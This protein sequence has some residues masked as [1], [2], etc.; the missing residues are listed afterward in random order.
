MRTVPQGVHAV[1]SFDSQP[2][3]LASP[4]WEQRVVPLHITHDQPLY[5]AMERDGFPVAY[6]PPT[7]AGDARLLRELLAEPDRPDSDDRALFWCEPEPGSH[8]HDTARAAMQAFGELQFAGTGRWYTVHPFIMPGVE[9]YERE[10]APEAADYLADWVA[11][12][13]ESRLVETE[14]AER[15]AREKRERI[16]REEREAQIAFATNW[17]ERAGPLAVALDDEASDECYA[18]NL[19]AVQI[20]PTAAGV[21][22]LVDALLSDYCRRT[23][24]ERR[25]GFLAPKPTATDAA[26]DSDYD[27]D[28]YEQQRR[29]RGAAFD[30]VAEFNYQMAVRRASDP[31]LQEYQADVA[32]LTGR[33]DGGGDG[34]P[35]PPTPPQPEGTLGEEGAA[36]ASPGATGR[37]VISVT[38]NNESQVRAAVIDELATSAEWLFQGEDG[39]VELVRHPRTGALRI[40]PLDTAGIRTIITEHVDVTS[41]NSKGDEASVHPPPWL[42]RAVEVGRPWRGVRFLVG[43]A[44]AP[45][46]RADG[47]LCQDIGYDPA[48]GLYYEP[49]ADYAPIPENPTLED[50]KAAVAL[51]LSGVA[52]FPFIDAIDRAAWLAYVLTLAGRPAIPGACPFFFATAN[53]PGSGKTALMNAAVT[54]VTGEPADTASY[55]N[56]G[57]D[58]TPVE[59]EAEIRKL[60]RA[61]AL[62]GRPAFILDNVPNGH[63]FGSGTL[64]G[65]LTMLVNSDRTLGGNDASPLP[66][67]TVW[68]ATGNNVGPRGDSVRRCVGI[69]LCSEA[70]HPEEVQYRGPEVGQWAR[71]ERHRLLPA[72]LTILVAYIRAGKP[73]QRLPKMGSFDEWSDLVRSALVWC[74]QPDCRATRDVFAADDPEARQTAALI[75]LLAAAG[76]EERPVT[77]GHV[78]GLVLTEMEEMAVRKAGAAAPAGPPTPPRP[79]TFADLDAIEVSA[80]SVAAAYRRAVPGA[81]RIDATALGKLLAK[82]ASRTAGGRRIE[83]DGENRAKVAQWRVRSVASS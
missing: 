42:P 59:D 43:V 48:S 27:P 82:Y 22:L 38:G 62:A 40:A 57:S 60:G 36:P 52:Q 33:D 49:T 70:E 28:L 21:R 50:A 72:A 41:K 69:R 47:S 71:A 32:T 25:I 14:K 8:G 9:H 15:R 77:A 45:I 23:D 55:P 76:A 26:F 83:K 20:T 66:A 78:V 12:I 63:A 53:S 64:D 58:R 2:E 4:N 19:D 10:M 39:L 74:G 51:L 18:R 31:R 75:D 30:L 3:F 6:V 67:Q 73:D 79:F 37:A 24:D 13:N 34:E 56:A 35:P 61:C 5:R 16:D 54:I 44:T 17:R 80:A 46:L 7:A 29:A 68:G 1:N 11:E 65:Q 81:G